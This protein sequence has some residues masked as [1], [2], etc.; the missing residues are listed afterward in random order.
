M[1]GTATLR[2]LI[3]RREGV[4][5]GA[6][7]IAGHRLAVHLLA[8]LLRTYGDDR[9][10]IYREYEYLTPQ[11]IDAALAYAAEHPDE[12]EELLRRDQQA[13]EQIAGGPV[14]AA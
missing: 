14:G 11:Q 6:P 3:E 4:C 10:R 13:Y 12:I 5:G 8:G 9:E 2:E 7:V 1:V